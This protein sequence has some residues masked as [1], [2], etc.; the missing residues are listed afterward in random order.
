MVKYKIDVFG[1]ETV[2]K[3]KMIATDLDGTF[4]TDDKRISEANIKAVQDA[5][6]SGIV[7]VP[8]TGRGLYTMP[9]NV[10]KLDGIRYIITSNGAS[11]IDRRAEEVIYKKQIS[12]E[13]A[14]EIVGHGLDIG[15][16]A[17]IFVGG[18][19]Y[20]LKRFAEDFISHGVN[21]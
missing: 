10:L 19:A 15:I 6:K 17:E 2:G 4:L 8:A 5:V 7:F 13:M 21:P 16:M 1:G 9:E 11:V 14:A 3:I 20:T 18:R 12:G